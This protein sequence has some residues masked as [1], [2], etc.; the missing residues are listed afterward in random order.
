MQSL[1]TLTAEL[2]VIVPI[3]FLALDFASGA[4]FLMRDCWGKLPPATLR[5]RASVQKQQQ[6]VHLSYASATTQEDKPQEAIPKVQTLQIA[7]VPTPT[8]PEEITTLDDPWLAEI[9]VVVESF[10][11]YA[12]ATPERKGAIRAPKTVYLLPPQRSRSL[13]S[14]KL[15]TAAGRFEH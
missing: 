9:E 13:N 4:V 11:Y 10:Y 7:I 15:I 5:G 6:L 12:P 3:L 14:L 8:D 1:L 2:I